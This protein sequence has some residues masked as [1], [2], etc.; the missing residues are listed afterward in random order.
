MNNL[1]DDQCQE[2]LLKSFQESKALLS[3]ALN[4]NW[5]I[6]VPEIIQI[7]KDLYDTYTCYTAL[8]SDATDSFN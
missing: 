8:F 6:I 5:A 4:E 1:K 2:L 7:A 3:D